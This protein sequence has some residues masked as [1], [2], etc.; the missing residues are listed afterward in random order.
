MRRALDDEADHS[1]Y[2][3]LSE[4]GRGFE[5]NLTQIL[6][7]NLRRMRST[8]ILVQAFAKRMPKVDKDRAYPLVSQD[9][10]RLLAPLRARE[11]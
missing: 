8:W 11:E 5:D 10:A 6:V 3:R 9:V 4:D 1:L 7:T 2:V